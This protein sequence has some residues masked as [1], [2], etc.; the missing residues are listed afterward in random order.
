LL[1]K[2]LEC[3]PSWELAIADAERG[4]SEA[5][6]RA[7][8]LRAVAAVFKRKKDAGEPWPGSESENASTHN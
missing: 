6:Q 2:V 8:R 7:V 5:E 4:A 3:F 1:E